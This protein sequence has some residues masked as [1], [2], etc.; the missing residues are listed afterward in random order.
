MVTGIVIPHETRLAL[1]KVE[2]QNLTDYQTAVGGYIETVKMDGHPLVIVADEDGKVKQLPVNRRATCLWWLLNPSG[3]G[4]DLLVGDVV[5]LGQERRGKT[6]DVPAKLL[7][8]LL[9]TSS[10]EVQVCLSKQFDTWVPIGRT[11][12]DFFEATIQALS[13]MEVWSPPEQVKVV[14]VK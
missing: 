6:N 3:L 12:T 8:L 1:Q 7:A 13:L 9:E 5:I 2:F 14:A 4:G 10:Y 11:H